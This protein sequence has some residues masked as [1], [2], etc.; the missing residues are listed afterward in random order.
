MLKTPRGQWLIT[1]VIEDFSTQVEA[2]RCTFQT[3][4]QKLNIA[5][6]EDESTKPDP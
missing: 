1:A 3:T 6:N 5:E 2:V 4:P